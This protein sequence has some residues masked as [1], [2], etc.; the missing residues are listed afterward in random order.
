MDRHSAG[1][2]PIGKDWHKADVKAALE[3]RGWSLRQLALSL[4]FSES[5]LREPLRKPYPA[6]ERRIA[7]ALGIHPMV[8]WP[9]RYD[10]NGKPNRRLGNPNWLPGRPQR[11]N[12]STA[13]QRGHANSARKN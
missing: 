3:K 11:R 6:A 12:R 10:E 13:P 5:L 8:I 1:T 4:G 2:K 9:S 7:D